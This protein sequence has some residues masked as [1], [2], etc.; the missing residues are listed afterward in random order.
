MKT[1]PMTLPTVVA[2]LPDD[3][4]DTL[5]QLVREW[6][7]R[8]YRN[9]LRR[10]Y[11]EGK[12]GLKDLG[13]AIPPQLKSFEVVVGWPAKA[14]NAMARRTKLLGFSNAEGSQELQA[15]V[16][17][18][19]EDN[20]LMSEFGAAHT[21]AL[22][23]GCVFA[24]VHLGRAE[25]GEPE[26]MVTIR[27]AEWATAEWNA[28]TRSLKSALSVLDI[29]ETAQGLGRPTSLALYLPGVVYIIEF[30]PHLNIY[31][32]VD[33]QEH[34]AGVPVEVIPFQPLL[35]R[36]FG[37]SRITRAVMYLTDAA[38]RTA[39]RTEVGAE[40]FNAPQRY[41]LGADEDAFTDKNGNPIPA[42]TVMLGR[43][44]TLTRDEEGNLPTVGQFA[45]QS[46]EPNLAQ[47][48]LNATMFAAETDLPVGSLGIVQDNPSSAEAIKAANDDLGLEIET[49]ES[50]ALGPAWQRIMRRAVL[51]VSDS[52]EALAAARTLRA[53]WGSWATPTEVSQAQ[54]SLARV[55]AIPALAQTTVELKK[56]GFTPD[57]IKQIQSDL[58]RA[59]GSGLL[60]SL[61]AGRLPAPRADD[62]STPPPAPVP[63]PAP[64]PVTVPEPAGA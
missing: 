33:V 42:W 6:Q 22:Q 32:V 3:A 58:R 24:F 13:I 59:Q 35:G 36:P 15:T 23:H 64:A 57:E 45:Q 38:A 62:G 11:Y 29:D 20:R 19:I 50:T 31:Q 61:A 18:I 47:Q 5:V 53:E 16:D 2:G 21:S 44:L 12:N 46:M 56:M 8:R 37:R 55:Q 52:P 27:D 30:L 49:W 60:A 25:L 4:R 39:L 9:Q 63:V 54:A 7:Q 51:M 1:R 26:V 41:A 17:Q 28:R 40:F 34:S 10:K 14:V 48:R 43:L